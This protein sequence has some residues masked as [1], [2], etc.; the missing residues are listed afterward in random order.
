MSSLVLLD[1]TRNEI[2]D[3]NE[4]TIWH[5]LRTREETAADAHDTLLREVEPPSQ[6]SIRG[7]VAVADLRNDEERVLAEAAAASAA[8]DAAED[9]Y[10]GA[11]NACVVAK[12]EVSSQNRI[13]VRLQNRFRKYRVRRKAGSKMPST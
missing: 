4:S 7:E 10:N 13:S 3:R 11:E 1:G 5:V 12:N 2:Y 6:P 9:A 8:F